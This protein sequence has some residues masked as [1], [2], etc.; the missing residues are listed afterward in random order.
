MFTVLICIV[1][2]H[3][4]VLACVCYNSFT[5]LE[6]HTNTLVAHIDGEKSSKMAGTGM[7]EKFRMQFANKPVDGRSEEL[8]HIV[9]HL[10]P[11]MGTGCIGSWLLLGIDD[12]A[13]LC[14]DMHSKEDHRST[15]SKV[16]VINCCL[17]PPFYTILSQKYANQHTWKEHGT[18]ITILK[19][20]NNF[21]YKNRTQKI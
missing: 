2:L 1:T 11:W 14:G 15:P 4:F 13:E 20:F 21:I 18:F 6:T 16:K 3:H 12:L 5:Q 19:A 9:G 7:L 17:R 8:I 10:V